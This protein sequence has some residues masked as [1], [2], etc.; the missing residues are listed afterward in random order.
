MKK[1]EPNIG[2]V[3]NFLV[4]DKETQDDKINNVMDA[5]HANLIG[6][7]AQ[8]SEFARLKKPAESALPGVS[9]QLL[10][11]QPQQHNL[12]LSG[13]RSNLIPEGANLY[14]MDTQIEKIYTELSS[15]VVNDYPNA[16]AGLFRMF[17]EISCTYYVEKHKLNPSKSPR[18]LAD[19]VKVVCQ[20]L[21]ETGHLTEAVARPMI[22]VTTD[23][24]H[25]FGITTLNHYVHSPYQRAVPGDLLRHWDNIAPFM[26]AMWRKE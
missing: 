16:V 12:R 23:K 1:R 7:D 6:V 25:L 14:I 9:T 26:K 17:V 2:D 21:V 3:V 8:P 22:T 18:T 19:L 13:S 15:L 10:P 4:A 20:H 11:L 5:V 24:D